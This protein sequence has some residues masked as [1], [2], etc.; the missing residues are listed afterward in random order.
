MGNREDDGYDALEDIAAQSPDLLKSILEGSPDT[1]SLSDASQP[2]LPLIY[3]NPSFERTTGYQRT[4]VLGRNCRFLQGEETDRNEVARLR[5]AI[6]D[7]QSVEVT[8]LN[9][10]KSGEPFLNA[11]RI[12]PIF[13][14]SGQLAA[15]L[16]I[17]RDITKER[18]RAQQDNTRNRLEALGTASGALAHQLNNLLH[19]VASLL[20][21]HLPDIE[22]A[23]MR[24][25]L[26]MALYS[27]QQAAELS[28]SLLG[29]SR[30]R[31][32]TDKSTTD[33]PEGLLRTVDLARMMVPTRVIIETG[34][35]N[36]PEHL[37]IPISETLFAQAIINLVMN[38]AQACKGSGEI[39]IELAST[40]SGRIKISIADNGPGI[41]DADFEKVFNPFY[42]TKLNQ[43]GTGLGLSV[44]LEII[45]KLS[46]L[47]Y[48][49]KGL[50]QPDG[51]GRGCMF[52]LDIPILT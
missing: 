51:N 27:A 19:P 4:D 13:D 52:T 8:L 12:A 14:R 9:Y 34:I 6:A 44:V 49:E 16:G 47:I 5:R 42:T 32:E 31:F 38:A 28:R 33:L 39:R 29:L 10:R 48:I 18:L 37:K 30:G 41:P 17:Q 22:D 45:N 20:S 21:L 3:V 35:G 2:D 23:G 50:L 26:E 1:I 11:L 43:N 7:R 36:F 24:K 15:Y 25:D 40:E 46:G